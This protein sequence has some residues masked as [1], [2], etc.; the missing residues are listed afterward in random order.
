LRIDDQP[1]VRTAFDTLDELFNR[2]HGQ[3]T[4]GRNFQEIVIAVVLILTLFVIAIVD[5][6]IPSVR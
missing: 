1:H 6:Q 2:W 4:H 5:I 3:F